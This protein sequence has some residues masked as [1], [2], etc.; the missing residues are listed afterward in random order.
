M[1]RRDVIEVTLGKVYCNGGK[2]KGTMVESCA[3]TLDEKWNDWEENSRYDGLPYEVH[4]AIWNYFPGGTTAEF[5]SKAV[6][7]A[8]GYHTS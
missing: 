3:K 2:T 1:S 7:S 5:A 4:M 6:L 8:L